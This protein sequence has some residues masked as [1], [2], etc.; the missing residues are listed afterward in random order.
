MN[1]IEIEKEVHTDGKKYIVVERD[2]FGD[3]LR[4]QECIAFWVATE[5]KKQW[6]QENL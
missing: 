3:V 1:Q 2:E 6:K 5:T 4:K